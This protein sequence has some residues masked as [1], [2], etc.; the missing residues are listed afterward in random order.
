MARGK[1]YVVTS[2]RQVRFNGVKFEPVKDSARS[3]DALYFQLYP[4]L[5]GE[6]WFNGRAGLLR[7]RAEQWKQ[8]IGS[9]GANSMA[10]D[11]G[12]GRGG[13]RGD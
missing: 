10:R 13:R 1:A 12:V 11:L 9:T 7:R 6:T 8:L 5:S 4:G 2:E 3:W